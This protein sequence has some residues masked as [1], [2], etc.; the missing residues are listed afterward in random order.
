MRCRAYAALAVWLS[1][2]ASLAAE[3]APA[4]VSSAGGLFSVAFGLAAV[5]AM[6]AGLAWMARR[7]GMTRLNGS[8][9]IRIVG[10]A[11]LGARERVAIIEVQETWIV[12]GVSSAGVTPLATLPKG[13]VSTQ[14]GVNMPEG[15]A[16]RLK[17][18][19]E[20]AAHARK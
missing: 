2:Q 10:A 9:L 15:F 3:P 1:T 20:A 13:N 4:A 14:A 19:L 6:I 12:V 5:I 8:A 16:G 18:L 11:S 17:T 7:M